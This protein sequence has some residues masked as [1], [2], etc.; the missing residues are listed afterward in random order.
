MCVRVCVRACARACV[1]IG[2][3]MLQVTVP[4]IFPAVQGFGRIALALVTLMVCCGCQ[5]ALSNHYMEDTSTHDHTYSYARD[6]K[7]H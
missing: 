3:V 1:F 4:Y 5:S 6:G 2:K 7:V